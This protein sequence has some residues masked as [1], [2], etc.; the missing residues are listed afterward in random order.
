[1][2][3][4]CH[5]PFYC[6]LLIKQGAD[7]IETLD[8]LKS[9]LNFEQDFENLKLEDIVKVAQKYFVPQNATILTL[10]K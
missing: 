10:T 7:M 6:N 5:N 4:I 8:D 2:K 3:S 1:M 9:L